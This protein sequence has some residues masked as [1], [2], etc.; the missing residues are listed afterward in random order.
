MAAMDRH[1]L[2]TTI[3]RR[4]PRAIDH[5]LDERSLETILWI[6]GDHKPA[7]RLLVG[8]HVFGAQNRQ[9]AVRLFELRDGADQMGRK[10]PFLRCLAH[11]KTPLIL[12]RVLCQPSHASRALSSMVSRTRPI[13]RS[14]DHLLADA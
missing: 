11:L 6:E 13:I 2:V 10:G 14:I 1:G 9:R 3:S 4:L 8:L 5:I 7:H 12:S